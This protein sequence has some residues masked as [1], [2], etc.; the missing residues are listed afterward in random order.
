MN[1]KRPL[2]LAGI[3]M[4]AAC[5]LLLS[6]FP[7]S[8]E[9]EDNPC[10]GEQVIFTGYVLKKE[11]RIMR[12]EISEGHYFEEK[13]PV[14][15]L[16]SSDNPDI[17]IKCEMDADSYVEQPLGS[18]IQVRGK[19]S[20]F[21]VA[22]NPGEFDS[23][24]YYMIM[25]TMYSL[26]GTTVLASDGKKSIIDEAMYRLR[27]KLENVFDACLCSQDA[28]IMKA[29]LLGNRSSMD[30]DTKELYKKSGII[31]ILAISGL[32]ISIIGMGIYKVL[33]KIHVPVMAGAPVAIIVMYLYGIM[34]GM[35]LSAFRAILM[36]T[37]HLGAN[38]LKRTYDMLTGVAAAAILLLIEQ[39]MY[40]FHSGFL[41]S[42]GSVTGIGLILPRITPV[43]IRGKTGLLRNLSCSLAV[44]LI[45]L[46]VYMSFYYTFP[47]FS[48]LLNLL[49]LPLMGLTIAIGILILLTGSI[50]ISLGIIPGWADHF[51]LEFY[52]SLCKITS[53]IPDNTWYTGHATCQ[54][55]ILYFILIVLFMICTDRLT[56]LWKKNIRANANGKKSKEYRKL[57]IALCL[58]YCIVIIA[59]FIL[60]FRKSPELKL[61]V[62]DVGQGDGIFV[63][64]RDSNILIDGGS[65]SK[66]K[67]E[68]YVLTPF[69]SYEG[70]GK[71]DAVV[72]THEDEDHISGVID[73]IE[74]MQPGSIQIENL[75]LPDVSDESKGKSYHQLEACAAE[76]YIPVSYISCGQKLLDNGETIITCLNPARG[77]RTD[78]PNAYSTVLFIENGNF[79]ALLTG[80]C[81]GEGQKRITEQI[82]MNKE[83]YGK[84]T[85]LK[86][87]H[88]G[89]N[90]TTD[91]AFINAAEP[92]YAAIS[93]GIDNKF[94]H[95]H[96]ELI[97]RLENAKICIRRTSESGALT[98]ETDG[99][100]MKI[101][102][103]IDEEKK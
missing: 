55:L 65:I 44:F 70:I 100:K 50:S 82:N 77:M 96:P 45:N 29:M 98:Y 25:K 22:T 56:D 48:V 101:Q 58:R 67:L 37:L 71:L 93:C 1:I 15:Y 30:N 39:P 51:L 66:S 13:I 75:I 64:C 90:G 38:M 3:I 2:C 49:V 11:D 57:R 86:V 34:C 35:N 21:P 85:L 28:S 54:G 79:K 78:E 9:Y 17:H 52:E 60:T 8:A 63:Q 32:H 59:V 97:K 36:F 89:S 62:I 83:K 7:Q 99:S 42:F 33:R 76:K 12:Y 24:R 47:V 84:L 87:A 103:F 26:K 41:M 14:L 10:D 88:H 68:K 102:S 23:R 72:I 95:P 40:V 81:D 94:G 20:N 91:N 19:V 61:T 53:S 92:A 73:L 18:C 16:K 5:Y 4:M 43:T 6:I 31:H 69:L 74:N 80:D 46:P 27:L